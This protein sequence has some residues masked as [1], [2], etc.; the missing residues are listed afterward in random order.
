MSSPNS[1]DHQG[2]FSCPICQKSFSS[3]THRKTHVINIHEVGLEFYKKILFS[4]RL[5]L[6]VLLSLCRTRADSNVT[7]VIEPGNLKVIWKDTREVI[8]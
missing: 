7:I 1:I 5:D 6:T 8:Q 3:K 4:I 2:A